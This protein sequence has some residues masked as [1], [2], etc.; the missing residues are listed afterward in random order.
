MECQRAGYEEFCS[1]MGTWDTYGIRIK[2]TDPVAPGDITVW[3]DY[4]ILVKVCV[5]VTPAS[6]IKPDMIMA[7]CCTNM[8]TF[9]NPCGTWKDIPLLYQNESS[10]EGDYGL[11]RYVYSMSLTPTVDDKFKLTFNITWRN[12]IIWANNALQNCI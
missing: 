2:W 4:P 11:C 9:C 3:R 8:K 7:N 12:I 1:G 10:S 6:G 5:E